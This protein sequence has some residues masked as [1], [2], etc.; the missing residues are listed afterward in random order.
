M[1]SASTELLAHRNFNTSHTHTHNVHRLSISMFTDF[2]NRHVGC[3]KYT[4]SRR[5]F[6]LSLVGNYHRRIA[7]QIVTPHQKQIRTA[8]TFH[9]KSGKTKNLETEGNT[10]ENTLQQTYLKD[11]TKYLF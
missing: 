1:D 7:V 2:K 5:F 3:V 9:L 11:N 6:P 10:G 8:L 4:E